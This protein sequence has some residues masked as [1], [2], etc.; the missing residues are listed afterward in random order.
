LTVRL[1]C[2]WDFPGKNIGTSCHFLLKGIFST[3]G[4]KHHLLVS[5]ALWAGSLP[6]PSG[7]HR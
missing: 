2:P 5:P 1:F 7:K 3:Q 6:E 4:L